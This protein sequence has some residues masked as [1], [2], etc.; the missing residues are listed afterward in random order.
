M[1]GRAL[2]R[3]IIWDDTAVVPPSE[4]VLNHVLPARAGI[5][6]NLS[7][8]VEHR[9]HCLCL[10]RRT[11]RT[12]N[13]SHLAPAKRTPLSLTRAAPITNFCGRRMSICHP[14]GSNQTIQLT[15]LR[16]AA[17]MP[18]EIMTSTLPLQIKLALTS[19][20]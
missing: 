7:V 15:R 1:E 5:K 16:R 19:G 13:I 18:P 8:T 6:P 20:G 4:Q 12:M 10:T 17:M 9:G 14:K 11:K 3:P 2:S